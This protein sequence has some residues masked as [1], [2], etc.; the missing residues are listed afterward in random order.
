MWKRELWGLTYIRYSS[1]FQTMRWKKGDMMS[2]SSVFA[3]SQLLELPFK[4]N[5]SFWS[6]RVSKCNGWEVTSW[7]KSPSGFSAETPDSS[8]SSFTDMLTFQWCGNLRSFQNLRWSSM[9]MWLW[10]SGLKFPV[11]SPHWCSALQVRGNG[12]LGTWVVP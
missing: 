10:W 3:M 8:E 5:L 12:G 2:N 9:L 11:L 1:Y 7:L 4:G 6:T